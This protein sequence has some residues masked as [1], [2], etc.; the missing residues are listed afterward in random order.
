M[1]QHTVYGDHVEIVATDLLQCF[2]N[3]SLS[4]EFLTGI[5]LLRKVGLKKKNMP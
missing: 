1:V 2:R 5:T 4:V 3:N